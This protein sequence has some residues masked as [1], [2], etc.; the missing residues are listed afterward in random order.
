MNDVTKVQRRTLGYWYLDGVVEMVVGVCGIAVGA[1]T[2]ATTVPGLGQIPRFFLLAFLI[3]LV[4]SPRW[5]KQLKERTTFPRT[6]FVEL[7]RD[8][9][10]SRVATAAAFVVVAAVYGVL[11]LLHVPQAVFPT[12]GPGLIGLV[13]MSYLA[14]WTGTPRLAVAGTIGLFGSVAFAVVGVVG[15]A[16]LGAS[17]LV[18]GVALLGTGVAAFTRYRKANPLGEGSES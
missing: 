4:L 13:S 15:G 9:S 16:G 18:V 5:V 11:F 17:L 2:W 3:V 8:G 14:W 10:P 12:L 7:R 1:A 6:G